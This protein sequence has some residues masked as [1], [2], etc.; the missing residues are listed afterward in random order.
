[1]GF[2]L[3]GLEFM[4]QCLGF[5]SLSNLHLCMALFPNGVTLQTCGYLRVMKGLNGFCSELYR[6][7]GAFEK[8]PFSYWQSLRI[9]CLADFR[10]RSKRTVHARRT[11]PKGIRTLRVQGP[12]YVNGIWG[13][14]PYYLGPW[15]L[16]GSEPGGSWRIFS[17]FG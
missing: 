3:W 16:R 6:Q 10:G 15:T 4:I 14:K 8:L 12:E 9:P 7:S 5:G 2:R 11:F 1:M 13:L 17:L